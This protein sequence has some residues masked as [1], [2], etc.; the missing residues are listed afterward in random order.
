M[1]FYERHNWTRQ[2]FALNGTVIPRVIG[3]VALVAFITLVLCILKM[4]SEPANRDS[5]RG[6]VSGW[7]SESAMDRLFTGIDEAEFSVPKLESIGHTV[8]GVALG[9][10]MAFRSNAA[11]T[12]YWEARGHWGMLVNSTRNL[13]RVG[14]VWAGP[15]DDLARLVS[16]YVLA[17]KQTL[18]EDREL[19]ELAHYLPGRI[20]DQVRAAGSPATCLSRHMEDWIRDKAT[21]GKIDTRTA[22]VMQQLVNVM[23]DQQGAC[24]KIHK[25][26][27]P[28]IYASLIKL[29]ITLFVF[30]LP[31][32]LVHTAS[33]AAPAIAAL[34]ALV[35]LGVEEAAIEIE[36]PFGLDFND[37]PLEQICA[38]IARD[39]S[40]LAK[41]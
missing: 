7:V 1:I 25:T 24:E 35:F 31:L 33:L 20:L 40:Q 26:P 6:L 34:V 21:L 29:S 11:N 41:N 12:R 22:M 4:A 5:L 38:T 14:H 15:A 16:A 23:V 13:V 8:L 32:V 30:T 17:I 18:R 3:R 9:M 37:L 10:L 39:V 27:M 36:D 28:F 2:V 19:E